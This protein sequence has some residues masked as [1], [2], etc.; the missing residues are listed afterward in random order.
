[1]FV[2]ISAV[3]SYLEGVY[4]PAIANLCQNEL[5]DDME[6]HGLVE[7]LRQFLRVKAIGELLSLTL[8]LQAVTFVV[9]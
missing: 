4:L 7:I 1:M 8:F 9:C 6:A 2:S 3:T 5:A